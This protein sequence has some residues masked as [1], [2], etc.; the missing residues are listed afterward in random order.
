MKFSIITPVLNRPDYLDNTIKSVIRQ[1]GNFEIEYIIQ[2]GGSN[3]ITIDLIK[4]WE[5]A[6]LEKKEKIHCSGIEF[7]WYSEPDLGMYDAV[8]KGF[9]K[10]TGD[11]LAW[12]NSDDFYLPG[13]FAT[14][15]EILSN[16]PE[17]EWLSGLKAVSNK[18][19]SIVEIS[20][21]QRPYYRD[22]VKKGFYQ[23]KYKKYG[24]SWIQQDCLFW[25][26]NLWCRAST[27][28]LMN[29]KYAGDFFL[30]REFARFSNLVLVHS[31]FSSYRFHGDQITKTPELYVSEIHKED[32]SPPKRL[33]AYNILYKLLFIFPNIMNKWT[34]K[35]EITYKLLLKILG[36]NWRTVKAPR[37][38]WCHKK[39][40]WILE[41]TY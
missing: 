38:K 8:A 20:A 1:E 40:R 16:Y 10:S 34:A 18:H 6:I 9:S 32:F 31:I 5:T 33:I 36:L 27:N 19:N 24:F 12:I 13:A 23:S 28:D 2:D 29:K 30:W 41:E 22:Y 11:I 3:N 39:Q 37:I 15:S 25:R 21:H 14:V 7:K 17:V 4:K 35:Y 26:K